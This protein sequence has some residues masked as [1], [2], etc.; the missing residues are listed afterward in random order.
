[1]WI[2]KLK[3]PEGVQAGPTLCRNLD[4]IFREAM[5]AL[6]LGVGPLPYSYL[7]FRIRLFLEGRLC[8]PPQKHSVRAELEGHRGGKSDSLRACRDPPMPYLLSMSMWETTLPRRS[9]LPVTGLLFPVPQAA[10]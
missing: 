6:R 3:S 5:I 8:S 2:L 10:R 4:F 9:R 1:M 7:G